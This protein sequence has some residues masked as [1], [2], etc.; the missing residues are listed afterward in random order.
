VLVAV[1]P[2]VAFLR[3]ELHAYA[4]RAWRAPARQ[5]A[6]QLTP[7]VEWA[8]S[9]TDP[10]DVLLVEGEQVIALY[11]GRQAAEYTRRDGR[12]TVAS[13][14][15]MLAA[16]PATRMATISPDVQRAALTLNEPAV[17]LKQ[18]P[19]LPGVAAFEVRR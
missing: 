11:T 1:L 19:A 6:A 14:R 10:R 12:A 15:A 7:L 3:T 17:A 13:L 16:V 4:T 9:A 18:V 8:G 5:A 2:A